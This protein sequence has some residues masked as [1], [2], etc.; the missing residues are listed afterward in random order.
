[1]VEEAQADTRLNTRG[2][3]TELRTRI[4]RNYL[5][6]IMLIHFVPHHLQWRTKNDYQTE[7]I[8]VTRENPP[9]SNPTTSQPNT[10][11]SSFT[12]G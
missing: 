9:Q 8:L 4:V 10:Q 6:V 5:C 3:M 11:E 2:E 1:M 12:R 7:L